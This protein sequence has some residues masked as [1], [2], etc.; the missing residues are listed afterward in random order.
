MTLALALLGFMH[1]QLAIADRALTNALDS[2]NVTAATDAMIYRA[3]ER[4]SATVSFFSNP[5]FPGER[6]G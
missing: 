3:L 2:N 5:N 1:R 6:T 4:N